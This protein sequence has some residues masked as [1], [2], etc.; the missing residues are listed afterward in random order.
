MALFCGHN[1]LN[2]LSN[3][4]KKNSSRGQHF[5]PILFYTPSAMV[6]GNGKGGSINRGHNNL[7]PLF[8]ENKKWTLLC[9]GYNIFIPT[10]IGIRKIMG[11]QYRGGTFNISKQYCELGFNVLWRSKYQ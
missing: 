4:N 6:I 5:S 11:I 2:P 7:N 8:N 10:P 3:W 1:I 9:R